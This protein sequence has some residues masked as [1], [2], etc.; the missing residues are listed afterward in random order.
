MRWCKLSCAGCQADRWE[1]DL[2]SPWASAV[3]LGSMW[4][5]GCRVPLYAQRVSQLSHWSDYGQPTNRRHAHNQKPTRKPRH[6]HQQENPEPRQA[7]RARQAVG[8][9]GKRTQPQPGTPPPHHHQATTRPKAR[10]THR[11]NPGPGDKRP[12][13]H[14]PHTWPP[15]QP[16]HQGREPE[17]NPFPSW[18]RSRSAGPPRG[19]PLPPTPTQ[20]K[21]RATH[22]TTHTHTPLHG[23]GPPPFPGPRVPQSASNPTP[24]L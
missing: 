18:D 8:E 12:R 19:H 15:S 22:K 14:T 9:E 7:S 3:P 24:F 23:S 17:K 10:H 2:P 4:P 5:W 6:T 13:R 1:E 16:H 21:D 20:D 11:P